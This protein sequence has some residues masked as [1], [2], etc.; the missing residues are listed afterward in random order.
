MRQY[1]TAKSSS[2][3]TPSSSPVDQQLPA[4]SGA[5]TQSRY[6]AAATGGTQ[7]YAQWSQSSNLL[8]VTDNSKNLTIFDARNLTSYLASADASRTVPNRNSWL[9]VQSNLRFAFEAK[10]IAIDPYD[11]SVFYAARTTGKVSVCH[12][13]RSE[14]KD[15]VLDDTQVSLRSCNSLCVDRLGRYALVG[16]GTDSVSLLN[17]NDLSC[18]RTI[19]N[20]GGRVS[21]V[22][23]AKGGLVAA[24]C[25][26]HES[27]D[28]TTPFISV[29]NIEPLHI[30]WSGYA[31]GTPWSLK[32]SPRDFTFAYCYDSSGRRAPSSFPH[33]SAPRQAGGNNNTSSRNNAL[34]VAGDTRLYGSGST[35]QLAPAHG[36]HERLTASGSRSNGEAWRGSS[37]SS[38]GR[39]QTCVAFVSFQH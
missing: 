38:S 30:L 28:R 2:T 18:I 39:K 23:F 5:L 6:T 21:K 15:L 33:S 27:D 37:S 19:S 34:H 32:W 11:D 25:G 26:E 13:G 36:S 22:D 20:L 35:S 9:R 24:C 10:D 12:C 31:A 16:C 8:Y 4:W 3:G 17:A 29:L 14:S 7:L 1:I